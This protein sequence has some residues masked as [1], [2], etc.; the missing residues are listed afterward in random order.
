LKS[1]VVSVFSSTAKTKF[2]SLKRSQLGPV[3]ALVSL[4]TTVK[5]TPSKL[6]TRIEP[7]EPPPPIN[8]RAS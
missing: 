4:A 5:A 3:P 8:T 2:G 6:A 1:L 7:V